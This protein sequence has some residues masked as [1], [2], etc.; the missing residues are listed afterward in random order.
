MPKITSLTVIHRRPLTAYPIIVADTIPKRSIAL[1]TLKIPFCNLFVTVHPLRRRCHLVD[2][3][4][5]QTRTSRIHG[6]S[7]QKSYA[8]PTPRHC[9]Q[10]ELISCNRRAA[11]IW[12]SQRCIEIGIFTQIHWSKSMGNV[13]PWEN[14]FEL[15]CVSYVFLRSH[16]PSIGIASIWCIDLLMTVAN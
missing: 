9:R 7:I 2:C 12:R 16:K 4:C 3:W 11:I 1:F 8:Q 13:N 5:Q 14:W 6:H 10:L 15:S